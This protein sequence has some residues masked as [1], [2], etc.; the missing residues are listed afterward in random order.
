MI[1][2]QQLKEPKKTSGKQLLPGKMLALEGMKITNQ[3][4]FS[5]YIDSYER[6]KAKPKAKKKAA[7]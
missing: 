5:V 3:N 7:K 4:K 6:K 1:R 2:I